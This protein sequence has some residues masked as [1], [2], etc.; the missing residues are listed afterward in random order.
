MEIKQL[1]SDVVDKI[2]AGEVVERPSHLLK[3]LVENSIDAGATTIEIEVDQGGKSI[4]V[5]DD[6]K[7]VLS[8]EI[9]LVFARHATS[10]IEESEDLWKLNTFG[11]RGEA[12][13]SI[14]SVSRLDFISR[15]KGEKKG[16]RVHCEFGDLSE[17]METS[18]QE[19]TK[20]QISD[21][22]ENIP[23]R[24]KFL[25]SD[26]A[27]VTQIKNVIK[28]MALQYPQV[29]WKLKNKGKLV[30]FWQ[31]EDSLLARAKKVL[32]TDRLYESTY[33][34]EG[35]KSKV[36][37]SDPSTVV[38]VSRQ[39]WTFVQNRWVLDRGIQAAVMEAYRSLLMHGQYPICFVSVEC[40]PD[41]VDVNIHPTKSQVKFV[42]AK[43]AFRVVHYAL[44]E[45]I[46]KAPWLNGAN[47]KKA[48]SFEPTPQNQ[49]F[50]DRNLSRTQFQQKS[51]AWKD[52]SFSDQPKVGMNDLKEAGLRDFSTFPEVAE[53]RDQVTAM[54][55][56][57]SENQ[58]EPPAQG[59]FWSSLQVVGQVD[60]TYIVTQAEDRMVLV[61][62]HAA[63]ER[64][65]FEKLMKA[66]REGN[67][68]I[69]S[70][71]LPLTVD[72]E[73]Q[74]VEVL[75][76]LSNDLERMGV[77]IE[78]AGPAT[79]AIASLPSII[80]E[81][82]LVEALQKLARESLEKGGSFALET[83]IADLFATM[84]C[85]SVIRAGQALSFEEMS[86]LLV[87]MDEFPLSGFCPH[88]RSVSLEFSFAKLEKDFGRRV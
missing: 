32:E 11:F 29:E 77:Q 86:Q 9:P 68:E 39:I 1:N 21:L 16:Y 75:M 62:Q 49:T 82:G 54:G 28:A 79:L 43:K 27:E 84:A 87:D 19:G 53:V 37:F 81:K 80:K 48:V 67:M 55:A 57:Q 88:G 33:E 61:D 64:V 30:Y 23:A 15:R 58:N 70:L 52:K 65:A 2:A 50:T 78:Q 42:D 85:H 17:V 56:G 4:S 10:K 26:S 51:M 22:F 41:E 73:E 66:W 24:L 83:A 60:L 63:H 44:R 76:G 71:L 12:L 45:A 25:K 20:V 5:L 47:K 8:D 18:I 59:G 46:G 13:A 38:K 14:S 34:Y 40:P 31:K 74:E 35:F 69:Q 6:G 36:I 3:E 72:L 7:G